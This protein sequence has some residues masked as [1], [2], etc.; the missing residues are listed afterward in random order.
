MKAKPAIGSHFGKIIAAA[1]AANCSTISFRE[2]NISC[3]GLGR[4][5]IKFSQNVA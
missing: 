5:Y 4:D 1:R 2:L 3:G